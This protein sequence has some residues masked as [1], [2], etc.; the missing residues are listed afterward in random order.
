MSLP[1]Y[2]VF[3][4][5]DRISCSNVSL[6]YKFSERYFFMKYKEEVTVSFLLNSMI[7]LALTLFSLGCATKTPVKIQHTYVLSVVDLDDNPL[8]GVTIEYT[9]TDDNGFRME[10]ISEE[11]VVKRDSFITTADGLLT[12]SIYP[13]M[14]ERYPMADSYVSRKYYTRTILEYE[15]SKEGF[16]PKNGRAYAIWDGEV[17]DSSSSLFEFLF[18]VEPTVHLL[19]NPTVETKKIVLVRP[20]DYFDKG[21]VSDIELKGKV[22]RF[23]DLIILE[24]RLT[25]SPLK[26]SSIDI[27]TFKE[28]KYLQFEFNNLNVFNSL[29]L[30]KYDIGKKVFDEVI[31]KI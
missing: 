15:V 13:M 22:I 20:I 12:E 5:L 4:I 23:I 27:V 10:K 11:K 30:D 28:K 6:I 31:R 24:S 7:L 25:K 3:S 19:G 2:I 16:Y 18:S 21:F 1:H 26:L 29:K 17:R 8:D 14:T 9:I